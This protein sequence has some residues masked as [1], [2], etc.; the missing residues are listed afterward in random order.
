MP[1]AL[2]FSNFDALPANLAF[3]FL[4]SPRETFASRC[5]ARARQA[6]DAETWPV[7][8]ELFVSHKP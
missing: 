4:Y 7:V 6:S 3:A 1:L 8:P 5:Q 2:R